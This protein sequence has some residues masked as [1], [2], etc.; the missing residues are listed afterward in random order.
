MNDVKSEV[1]GELYAA[2]QK[3]YPREIGGRFPLLTGRFLVFDGSTFSLK[4]SSMI[5][6]GPTRPSVPMP[7]FPAA[8]R[9]AASSIPMPMNTISCRRSPYIGCQVLRML[10]CHS[11]SCGRCCGG[12]GL[13]ATAPHSLDG[14][15]LALDC[16]I[17]ALVA[18]G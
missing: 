4:I 13:G 6:P 15:R 2:R 9:S 17:A 10:A 11:G 16:A 12:D 8:F 18:H 5:A 7:S 1:D 3:I 14:R